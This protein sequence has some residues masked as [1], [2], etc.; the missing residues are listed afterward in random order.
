MA[1]NE[2]EFNNSTQTQPR[3]ERSCIASEQRIAGPAIGGF[4]PVIDRCGIVYPHTS[5]PAARR[6]RLQSGKPFG[7]RVTAGGHRLQRRTVIELPSATLFTF[8]PLARRALGYI[9]THSPHREQQL[10]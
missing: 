5:K 3:N 2:S 10:V 8:G 6:R 9:W 7:L 1:R 4:I